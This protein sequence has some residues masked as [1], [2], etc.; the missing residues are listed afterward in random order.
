M[1]LKKNGARKNG[2]SH[3]TLFDQ[4]VDALFIMNACAFLVMFVWC[5]SSKKIRK[6]RKVQSGRKK[7]SNAL[8]DWE[9]VAFKNNNYYVRSRVRKD[10]RSMKYMFLDA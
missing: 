3:P 9:E 5:T 2:K 6:I 7:K 1:V 8:Y 10:S 4:T